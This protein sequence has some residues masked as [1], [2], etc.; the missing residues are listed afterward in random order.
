MAWRTERD[1]A[2]AWRSLSGNDVSSG[3]RLIPVAA[4]GGCTI[5]AG[6]RFPGNME[7]L[8]L[9]F[10]SATLPAAR[11]LPQGQGFEVA[12]EMPEGRSEGGVLMTLT[13]E[14]QGSLD[15]F[16]TMADDVIRTLVRQRHAQ[17]QRLLEGFLRRVLA[18]QDFMSRPSSRR[19]S[20]EEEVGLF[21][22]L[23]VLGQLVELGVPLEE[24]VD[25]WEG[26]ANG[27]QDFAL[28]DGAIE[29]KSSL[30][31]SGFPARIGSL[32]QLDDS[33]RQ[34]LFLAAQRLQI[35]TDG[36]TLPDLVNRRRLQFAGSGAAA[37]LE[38]RLGQA[39][40]RDDH[41]PD[42]VRR[43]AAAD[44]RIWR[45]DAAFPRL[46]TGTVPS[47]VRQAVYT[48]ELDQVSAAPLSLPEALHAL[49]II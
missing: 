6:R 2:G 43:F 45:V 47:T 4:A 31:A 14:A 13:R 19:L 10:P 17:P 22:E 16:E 48:L 7:A 37:R 44:L 5:E 32:E 21:G 29:V 24:A 26:P 20:A 1:L 9:T 15:L 11:Q 28:G 8:V 23:S 46:V 39:G 25:S 42:Y 30:A 18:W 3:W 33:V 27:V 12:R 36:W 41:S 34:P 40:F 35:T 38:L 49:E